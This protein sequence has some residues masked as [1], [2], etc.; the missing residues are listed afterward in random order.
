MTQNLKHSNIVGLYGHGSNGYVKSKNVM[1]QNNLTYLLMECVQ[2]G[3]LIDLCQGCGSMGEDVGRFFLG[4]MLDVL[5]YMHGKNIVHR[6]LKPE[7][8]LLDE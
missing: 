1:K 6:D 4:Q 5:G 3:T 2:S 8:I 7:N